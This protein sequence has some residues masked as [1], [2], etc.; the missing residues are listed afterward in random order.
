MFTS[1][2]PLGWKDAFTPEG[3]QYQ[4]QTFSIARVASEQRG[5]Y[6]IHNGERTL[7]AEASGKVLYS[8]A[9]ESEL[10]KVGDWVAYQEH[11]EGEAIIHGVLSR[12]TVLSRKQA[13]EDREQVLAANVDLLFIMQGLDRDFNPRRLERYLVLA[14]SAGIVPVVL[15]N[16][17]DLVENPEDFELQVRKL[18]PDLLVLSLSALTDDTATSVLAYLREGITACIVG[19]SGVGKSTLVNRLLGNEAQ[20]TFAVREDD[21]RGRHTTTSRSLFTLPGGGI[22]ID[23]PGMRELSPWAGSD[24]LSDTFAE[25][26]ELAEQCK[27]RDCKHEGEQGCAIQAALESGELD[28]KRYRNYVKLQRELDYLNNTEAYRERKERII[29]AQKE[30]YTKVYKGIH[31]P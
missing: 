31:R 10:P 19:S 7:R 16:K 30:F 1:L 14:R 2:I 8:I 18:D 13:G 26:E 25:I 20:Q 12:L 28:A 9:D 15:L 6:Y 27:F 4:A 3:E 21:Q 29:K 17:A 23:T 5:H 22:L 11:T 24:D